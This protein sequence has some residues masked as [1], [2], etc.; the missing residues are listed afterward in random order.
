LTDTVLQGGIKNSITLFDNP[1]ALGSSANPLAKI[2]KSRASDSNLSSKNNLNKVEWQN[3]L[4][5]FEEIV[6]PKKPADLLIESTTY[7]AVIQLA[8]QH[9]IV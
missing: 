3:N 6:N 4:L 1:T 5:K 7:R 2:L 9:L 8:P